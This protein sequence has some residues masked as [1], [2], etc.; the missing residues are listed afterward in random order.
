[1]ARPRNY[2]T[3]PRQQSYH[4]EEAAV[5]VFARAIDVLTFEFENIPA[6]TIAW[7]TREQLVR[8]GGEVLLIAQNRLREKEF[9]AG[10]WLSRRAVSSG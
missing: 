4:D 3:A 10:A 1:M 8:P 5:T 9:L 7:A 6:A 2:P